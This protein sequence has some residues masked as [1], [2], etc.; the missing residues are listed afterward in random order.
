M[1]GSVLLSNLVVHKTKIIKPTYYCEELVVATFLPAVVVNDGQ[2][3]PCIKTIPFI[4][5]LYPLSIIIQNIIRFRFLS[6]HECEKYYRNAQTAE[7]R[8]KNWTQQTLLPS[9]HVSGMHCNHCLLTWI[10]NIIINGCG[11]FTGFDNITKSKMVKNRKKS[12]VFHTLEV[13][14]EITG[15]TCLWT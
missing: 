7:G 10:T 6:W 4:V 12:Q 3:S 14:Y 1:R 2:K 9:N 11:D 13:P 15:Y 5:L 8:V